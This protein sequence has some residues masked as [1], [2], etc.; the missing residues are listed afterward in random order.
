MARPAPARTSSKKAFAM[1]LIICPECGGTISDKATVCVH[2]GHPLHGGDATQTPQAGTGAQTQHF[3]TVCGTE[4]PYSVHFCTSC[5]SPVGTPSAAAPAQPVQPPQ[6]SAQP[7]APASPMPPAP[8]QKEPEVLKCPKCGS[9]LVT[10]G[11]RGYS[12]IW[13]F[14][15]AGSTVNRC[16]KCGFKWK[17]Y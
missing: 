17:P 15:G 1:A 14:M 7:L 8:K 4:L 5:G 6:V 3:C 16:G 10:T 11:E 2:C 13:G 9:T 12:I